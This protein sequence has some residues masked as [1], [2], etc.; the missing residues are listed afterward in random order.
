M[1]YIS[2]IA[3]YLE[4]LTEEK[5]KDFVTEKFGQCFLNLKRKSYIPS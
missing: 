5:V 4:I 2:R 3:N 1:L